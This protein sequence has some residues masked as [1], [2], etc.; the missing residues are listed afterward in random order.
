MEPFF[1]MPEIFDKSI[2]VSFDFF[3]RCRSSSAA[4]HGRFEFCF[5]SRVTL[6]ETGDESFVRIRK[7][8]SILK[9]LNFRLETTRKGSEFRP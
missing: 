3:F 2:E 5:D 7:C 4:S 8:A 9:F 6:Q 1:Q